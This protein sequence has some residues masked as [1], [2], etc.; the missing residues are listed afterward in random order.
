MPQAQA[1]KRDA[2]WD[3]ARGIGM[4]LVIY[5]HLLEPMYPAH[6]GRPVVEAA[7]D[8]W[9]VIYSFH[10]M[11]FFLVSG[12]VNRSLPKKAWPDVLRGSLRLLALAWVVHIIGAFVNI[13]LQPELRSSFGAATWSIVDPILEG[14]KW[15]VGV[16]WFLTSLCFVQILAYLSLRRFPAVAVLIVAMAATAITNYL[17]EQYMMKT[18]APGL[19]FFT[20]GYLFSQWQVR[21]PFWAAIPLIAATLLLAPLNHGCTFS[22]AQTCGNLQ[23]GPFGVQIFAG[24]YGFLPL[25]FL[26]SLVGSLAVVCLSAG[27]ARLSASDL[28]AYAG[29][30]SLELF[31][32]NGFVATFLRD[33]FWQVEWPHLTVFHYV[34]LFVGI[35]GAHLLALQILGPVLAWINAAGSA[36]AGFLAGILTGG[37]GEGRPKAL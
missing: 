25:F 2:T 11:L 7:A 15:S 22:F 14:Y 21:W 33:Y 3:I 30:K 12:A 35:V 24:N 16:L 19:A 36:I 29:R 23:Y 6:N 31:F 4:A 13:G 8:Q 10:M 9:Q 26:S 5:G 20:I 1:P 28:L 34:G 27:F 17:P 18:W 37:A 32:I